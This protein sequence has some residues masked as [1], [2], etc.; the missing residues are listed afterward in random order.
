MSA[1]ALIDALAQALRADPRNGPLWLHYAELLRAEKRDAEALTALRTAAEITAVRDEALLKLIPML[2]NAG[3]LSEALIR[4]ESLLERSDSLQL[5]TELEAI[6]AARE[7]RAADSPAAAPTPT[8]QPSRTPEPGAARNLLSNAPA[9][10][11]DA[12]WA[13][14]FDW[15]D[16]RITLADVAGLEDVKRQIRLRIL[17]PFQK[18]EIYT[19]FGRSGGGGLLLYGPPGCGKTFIARATAGELGA[20]FV[21]V[22]IHDMLDKYFGESEK[23]IHGLFEHARRKKPTVLFFDEFDALASPRGSSEQQFWK[24]LVDQLLQ[25][26]DG[27]QSRNKDVLLLAAT[28]VPWN[29][30]PAFRR[31][32]RFDR[33]LFVTPPDDAARKLMLTKAME[34]L[35]GGSRIDVGPLVKRTQMYSG[36]DLRALCERAAEPALDRSLE[37]GDVHEVTAAD[38]QRALTQVRSS[39]LEWMASAR[40]HARYSNEGGQYDE[41]AEYLKLVQRW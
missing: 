41:L 19:A 29:V 26:M 28:N 21:S 9:R 17:A 20:R 37:D 1:N 24:T 16:L 10:A 27:V 18:P 12:D 31:P 3:Q 8:P 23:L 14:Q 33:V 34:S 38:F 13:A 7:G 22:S 15:G 30:D 39:V 2:R 5:R 4:A 11:D 40:N 36:A 6:H 25:E 35:P 32:G